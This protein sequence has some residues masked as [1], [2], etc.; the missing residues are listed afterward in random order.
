MFAGFHGVN[1]STLTAFNLPSL[2]AVT[3][4]GFGKR[5]PDL[6]PALVGQASLTQHFTEEF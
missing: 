5:G 1:T 6:A 2:H 4:R 3:Q